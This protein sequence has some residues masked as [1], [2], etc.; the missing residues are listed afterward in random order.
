M[1][2]KV[3]MFDLIFYKKKKFEE[4]KILI[5]VVT[6]NIRKEFL[7]K[8]TIEK[9]INIRAFQKNEVFFSKFKD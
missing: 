1:S 2:F 7:K 3:F 8:S 4:F 6:R 9:P 5:E